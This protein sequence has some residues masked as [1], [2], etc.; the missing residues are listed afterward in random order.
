MKS[1]VRK[2]PLI[3]FIEEGQSIDQSVLEKLMKCYHDINIPQSTEADEYKMF[4]EFQSLPLVVAQEKGR[5]G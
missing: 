2:V 3:K 4:N 1:E 5:F